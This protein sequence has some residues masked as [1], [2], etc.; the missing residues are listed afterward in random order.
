MSSLDVSLAHHLRIEST[1]D[2]ISGAGDFYETLLTTPF[3]HA[4]VNLHNQFDGTQIGE[5]LRLPSDLV[6]QG[7]PVRLQI[8][9]LYR[10]FEGI[11]IHEEVHAPY[12]DGKY[13]REVI[14]D[15]ELAP[16]GTGRS[17]E[18]RPICHGG[19]FDQHEWAGGFWWR[20]EETDEAWTWYLA[21]CK[22]RKFNH[23]DAS[24]CL[25]GRWLVFLGDS[26]T[27]GESGFRGAT[28][29]QG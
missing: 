15:V 28:G 3:Y 17:A 27:Q 11:E 13:T 2:G 19:D 16:T 9:R 6:E 8:W 20:K 1:C 24:E 10:D 14:A 5:P 25:A 18:N 4:R 12:L 29:C 21:E 7:H 23:E 26:T 22:A